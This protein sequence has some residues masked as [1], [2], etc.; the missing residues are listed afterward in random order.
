MDDSVSSGLSVK[1]EAMRD[2]PLVSITVPVYNV[3]N[4]LDR[5][6]ES[7][8]HQSYD[9]LEIILIDDASTD[10]SA[11]MCDDWAKRDHRIRVIHKASNEGPSDARKTGLA[12]AHGDFLLQV[13][14]DDWIDRAAVEKAVAQAQQLSSDLVIFAYRIVSCDSRGQ[15]VDEQIVHQSLPSAMQ[16]ESRSM[17]VLRALFSGQV[18]WMSWHFLISRVIYANPDIEM[19]AG[20]N[21]AEDLL[22]IVQC[23][24]FSHAP[25]LF[26]EPLYY[27][28]VRTGSLSRGNVS[29]ERYLCHGWD[30]FAWVFSFLEVFLTKHAP[31]ALP[32]F[33]RSACNMIFIYA[34]NIQRS[35]ICSTAIQ[36]RRQET[37]SS[38]RRLNSIAVHDMKTRCKVWLII[39]G[40]YR[41]PWIASVLGRII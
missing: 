17:T 23:V 19:P 10:N 1:G 38:M 13:D 3:E 22:F 41:F 30:Q 20:L 36:Q 39:S 29:D 15:V 34:V 16:N 6:V 7:L 11:V 9:N 32:F 21:N 27:W 8:I 4:F 26:D 33:A 28:R 14:S 35:H 18:H 25:C 37:E 12:H 31:L 24:V 40:L 2:Y 5:C